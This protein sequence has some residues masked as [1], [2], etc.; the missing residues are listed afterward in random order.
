MNPFWR[1][2]IRIARSATTRFAVVV[3][4]GPMRQYYRYYA[5]DE[6]SEAY[7]EYMMYS[8]VG[9]YYASVHDSMRP[10]DP[11]LLGGRVTARPC[12]Y[13]EI[14]LFQHLAN[15]NNNVMCSKE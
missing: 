5:A 6:Q 3:V 10:S 13:P 7:A 14:Y 12:H 2:I 11:R 4:H 9:Y 15:A 8:R 1:S